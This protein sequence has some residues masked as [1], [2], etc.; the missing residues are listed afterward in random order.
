MESN[1]ISF[2]GNILDNPAVPLPTP[3]EEGLERALLHANF[4]H[5]H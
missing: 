3:M 2:S 1:D 4:I 5:Q